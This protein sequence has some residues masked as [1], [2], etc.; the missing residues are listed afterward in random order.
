MSFNKRKP[1]F[2][3]ITTTLLDK[4]TKAQIKHCNFKISFQYVDTRP[5]FSSSF[6]DWQKDGLLSHALEVLK[7]YCCRPLLEQVD[8]EKFTIYGDFPPKE[9]TRFEFPD[10]V[11]QD[12]EWARIHIN[13]RA[14]LVGHIIDDT[15]YVVFLDKFHAFWL[16]KRIT[17]N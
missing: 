12:A 11:P 13:G 3:E 4:K 9:K 10:H 15:F 8:G 2:S 7:G 6:S 1:T 16:T 14:I 17:E 5:R